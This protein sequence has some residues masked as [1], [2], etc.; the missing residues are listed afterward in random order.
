M[1]CGPRN[2]LAPTGTRELLSSRLTRQLYAD[3]AVYQVRIETGISA[4]AFAGHLEALQ[5]LTDGTGVIMNC[6]SPR[7]VDPFSDD[8]G[9]YL[10][11]WSPNG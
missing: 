4:G 1:T 5:A 8:E 3:G 9:L 7:D 2:P 11:L 10:S 6:H